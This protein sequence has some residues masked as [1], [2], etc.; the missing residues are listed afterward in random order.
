MEETNGKALKQ[1]ILDSGS[2]KICPTRPAK[3][4]E[5]RLSG[6]RHQ[7]HGDSAS[8][9]YPSTPNQIWRA[10]QYPY[11]QGESR[12]LIEQRDTWGK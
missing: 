7:S 8:V 3:F 2:L 11:R 1:A 12:V 6:Q 10:S 9:A 5:E 4:R